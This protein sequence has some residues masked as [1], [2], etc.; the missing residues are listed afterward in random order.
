VKNGTLLLYFLLVCL[1][2]P[3]SSCSKFRVK[4]RH[5]QNKTNGRLFVFLTFSLALELLNESDVET[6]D[7]GEDDNTFYQC[8]KLL[9]TYIV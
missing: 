9:H 2:C 8:Y 7:V 3:R 5:K 1:T 4:M 6:N